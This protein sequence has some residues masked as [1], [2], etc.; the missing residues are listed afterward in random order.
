MGRQLKVWHFDSGP[1][2]ISAV[3]CAVNS[4]ANISR[5]NFQ[6]KLWKHRMKKIKTAVFAVDKLLFELSKAYKKINISFYCLS[7]IEKKHTL[8]LSV[9]KWI[10]GINLWLME[11]S[12]WYMWVPLKTRRKAN[13]TFDLSKSTFGCSFPRGRGW[14]S[15]ERDEIWMCTEIDFCNIHNWKCWIYDWIS[16]EYL[17]WQTPPA[18]IPETRKAHQMHS[19]ER[20]GI[21][22]A[23]K[24]CVDFK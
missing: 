16:G 23:A 17:L 3:V 7:R 1:E 10:C 9:F 11:R 24:N 22:T 19:S 8:A 2:P 20:M 6:Q 21:C 15:T 4:G 12:L 18:F 5:V 13:G 14:I